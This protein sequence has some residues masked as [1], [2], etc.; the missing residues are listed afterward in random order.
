M[1]ET[2][3]CLHNITLYRQDIIT[4]VDVAEVILRHRAY[5]GTTSLEPH[6]EPLENLLVFLIVQM[7]TRRF[8]ELD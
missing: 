1:S 4:A 6:S 8:R 2:S 7:K 5:M 3:I